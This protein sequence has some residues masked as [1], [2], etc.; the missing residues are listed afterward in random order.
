[1]TKRLTRI[2]DELQKVMRSRR[3]AEAVAPLVLAEERRQ[4]AVLRSPP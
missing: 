3:F 1:M 4:I 2:A